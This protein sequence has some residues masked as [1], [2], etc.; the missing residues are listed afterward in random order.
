MQRVAHLESQG[1][2]GSQPTALSTTGHEF[3][4]DLAGHLVGQHQFHAPLAGVSRATHHDRGLAPVRHRVLA[5]GELGGVDVE[6]VGDQR[7][8]VGALDREHRPLGGRVPHLDV[9]TGDRLQPV[10]DS[11]RVGRVGHD[12]PA[13]GAVAVDDQVVQHAAVLGGAQR[14]LRRTV[15]ERA[16]IVGERAVH[17]CRRTLTD[18]ED[19]AQ[20]G[21]VEHADTF[22]HRGVLHDRPG[23]ADRHLPSGELG[24]LRPG[25]GVAVGER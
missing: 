24:D 15:D 22:A 2:A 16:G 14:V 10:H 19:R 7:E 21:D 13:L 4:P 23:E 6:H 17:G 8:R 20:V 1:V 5:E 18:E 3:V 9:V 25:R 12:H 11:R